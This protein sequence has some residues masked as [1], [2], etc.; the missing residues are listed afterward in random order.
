MWIRSQD[1]RS[2]GDYK[3]VYIVEASIMGVSGAADDTKLGDYDTPERALEVI[4][5]LENHI[6]DNRTIF[7][8]PKE[9]GGSNNE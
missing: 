5:K 4:D 3:E 6:R 1:R 7:Y 2:F 9:K 8:M